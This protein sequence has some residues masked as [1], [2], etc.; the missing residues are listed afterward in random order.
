MG[1]V[2]S[3]ILNMSL[4]GGAVILVVLL[5]RLVLRRAPKIYSYALWAVVLFRLLCPVSLSAPVSFLNWLQP[6]VRETTNITSSVSY[7]PVMTVETELPA[8]DGAQETGLVPAAAKKTPD[9]MTLAAGVWLAGAALMA[10][11][12]VLSY[13]R[14]RR[15]LVGAVL[16]RGEVYLADHIG[17]P[18]VLGVLQPRVYLPSDTP[19]SERRY[20]IAHERQHIRRGDPLWKLLGYGALCIH[21]FNP[22][23]WAA[24]LLAGRDMEM[25]CDEAV[26]RRLGDHIRADYS[27]SLLRLATHKRIVAG[28]PLA[29]GEGDTKSRVINMARWKKP[30]FW[31]S[32]LCVMLCLCTLLVCTLNPRKKVQLTQSASFGPIS[33]RLP[34]K[35]T[36]TAAENGLTIA[37]DGQTAGG[38]TARQ[39]PDFAL[40]VVDGHWNGVEWV[41]ALGIPEAKADA[42]FTIYDK[43]AT[44]QDYP[45]YGDVTADY[46][47][48][49]TKKDGVIHFFYMESTGVYDIWFDRAVL[50]K[51]TIKTV[52]ESVSLNRPS[53]SAS[54]TLPEG[55]QSGK[56]DYGNLIILR[57]AQTVGGIKVYSLPEG[58]D[59]SEDTVYHWLEV[60]GISDFGDSNLMYSGGITN[61][62]GGW[63]A[64]F[65]S[66][67]QSAGPQVSRTHIFYVQ[68]RKIY[69][70][71]L[72]GTLL[73]TMQIFE[74]EDSVGFPQPFV[75]AAEASAEA[76]VYP[77]DLGSSLPGGYAWGTGEGNIPVLLYS[78]EAAGGIDSYPLPE[79]A[80]T[81]DSW[82]WLDSIGI[83]DY[84]DKSLCHT[85]GTSE[86]GVWET[87]FESDVTPGTE[88]TVDRFH[89]FFL[90]D[91]RLYD[92]WFD[93][94][95][96]RDAD[97][98]EILRI[99]TGGEPEAP[100]ETEG[101]YLYSDAF[102]SSDGNVS[103]Q[104]HLSEL[105][106]KSPEEKRLS[107]G[108]LMAKARAELQAT[109]VNDY[110]LDV[111]GLGY[112]DVTCR[113]TITEIRS[114]TDLTASGAS[115]PTLELYGVSIYR[116]ADGNELGADLPASNILTLNALD[117]TVLSGVGRK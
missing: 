37:L 111:D 38:V 70:F 117:G 32:G 3:R 89:T 76:L 104:I 52:M 23:V 27:A 92:V 65:E 96:M 12:S 101:D 41:M 25:S 107:F 88:G 106:A 112:K 50:D 7:L 90:T 114:G 19:L 45:C 28:M 63:R 60:S 75:A 94:K 16:Y 36:C 29:F 6:E 48:G 13:L 26:L 98:R 95:K 67:P 40:G 66:L 116:F 42:S 18:F 105:P 20:I 82:D 77:F 97:R 1:A 11:Y 46:I 71:W 113:I 15:R 61:F 58:V 62:G 35:L 51:K 22:L 64:Q 56:D 2:F 72:D 34:E 74:L 108:E 80:V 14:L 59:S 103:F 78:G 9:A 83:P 5:L 79:G 102:L 47:P 31:V 99:L 100:R 68:D 43:A 55:Y 8:F 44:G 73:D 24:F 86:Y 33:L 54:V 81:P 4:T 39:T 69:D 109:T 84:E 110:G 85:G 49:D 87:H 30:R 91:E 93:M 57:D 17:S 115:V 21:W 53:N 10:S